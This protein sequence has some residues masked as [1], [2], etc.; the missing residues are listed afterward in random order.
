MNAQKL[1]RRKLRQFYRRYLF[2]YTF[3]TVPARELA[4]LI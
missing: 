4:D 3:E 1:N 2:S